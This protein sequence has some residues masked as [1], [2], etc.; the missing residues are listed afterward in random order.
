MHCRDVPD[1]CSISDMLVT[2][3]AISSDVVIE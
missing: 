2:D 3:T 1:N